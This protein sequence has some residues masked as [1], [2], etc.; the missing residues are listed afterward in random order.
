VNCA[1]VP[2]SFTTSRNWNSYAIGLLLDLLQF[3]WQRGPAQD[4]GTHEGRAYVVAL[5]DDRRVYW[6]ESRRALEPVMTW[7]PRYQ[8][9][10]RI[11]AALIEI[12]AAR[13]TIESHAWTPMV[14][15]EIRFH[16]KLRS[17][18]YSTRIEGNRLTLAEA[19]DVVRGRQVAFA[20][21]QRDVGEVERYWKAIEK[22]QEWAE[23]GTPVTEAL[24]RQLHALV[25]K[26]PRRK[27]TPYREAQNSVRDSSSGGLVYLP[28]TPEDVPRL[29]AELV[30]WIGTAESAGVTAPII[31][32]LA[33]YQ[34]VTIHPFWDGNGRTARLLATLILDR[35]GLGLRGFY[36]L[37]EYHAKDLAEY[38]RQ[39]ASHPEHNYYDGRAEADLTPWLEYF[40]LGVAR[41]FA[42][43]AQEASRH[44]RQR[45][46]VEP[47]E[48]R[49]L[50]VRA[51]RVLAQFA[52]KAEI[53]AADVA[54]LFSISDRAA[55]D[56]LAKWVA[57]SF[58]EIAREGNRNRSY[59][60]SAVYRQ[61]VG[62]L[63]EADPTTKR[64]RK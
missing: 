60:L 48:V 26:G 3:A 10:D 17:T 37:E 21:R 36:S 35:G 59:R 8:I 14:E 1:F 6:R 62:D 43:A 4:G 40:T 57:D 52:T 30:E 11:A 16:A 18:H 5:A 22:V 61:Y 19:E 49:S 58:L 53:R 24:V 55:R 54:G 51:R 63:S 28:P 34:F 64:S 27:P 47:A 38:Y 42:V 29:M 12:G 32:G 44:A 41:T 15:E 20:G 31:A 33:H 2:A 25:D 23:K 56:L 45:A 13:G 9:N 50:D 39:L 46:L 7:Q